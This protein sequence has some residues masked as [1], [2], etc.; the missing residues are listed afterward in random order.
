MMISEKAVEDATIDLLKRHAL[1]LEPMAKRPY[2]SKLDSDR[3]ASV[4]LVIQALRE[5][6][7]KFCEYA[8]P[9]TS[10]GTW[11]SK[12]MVDHPYRIVGDES[13]LCRQ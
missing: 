6:V 8:L 9:Q 5:V 13:G 10:K 7:Q 12:E 11:M 3:L 4:A 1:A 2:Q